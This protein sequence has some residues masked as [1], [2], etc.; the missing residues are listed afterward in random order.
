MDEGTQPDEEKYA[1]ISRFPRPRSAKDLRS[2][3]GLAQQPAAFIPDLAHMKSTLLKK[4]IGW[5]WT[6][7]H[8][9]SL[10]E[11]EALLTSQTIIHPFD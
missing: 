10:E 6:D 3:L 11:V 1:A 7:D 2:F 4:D 8:E 9:S 5:T